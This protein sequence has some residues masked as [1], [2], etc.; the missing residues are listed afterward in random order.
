MLTLFVWIHSGEDSIG[1]VVDHRLYIF[2]VF[3]VVESD[4]LLLDLHHRYHGDPHSLNEFYSFLD[5]FLD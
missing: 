4:I 2:V 1:E 5:Y 3:E